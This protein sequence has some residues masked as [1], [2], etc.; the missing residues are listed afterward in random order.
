MAMQKILEPYWKYH[1]SHS[2]QMTS[3]YLSHNLFVS[4]SY[5]DSDD[6]LRIILWS[7]N[8]PSK[9]EFALEFK[10]LFIYLLLINI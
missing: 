8:T 7:E 6:S 5:V 3:Y 10:T 9:E 4:Y 1:V 2:W